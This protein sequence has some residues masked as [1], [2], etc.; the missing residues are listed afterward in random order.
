VWALTVPTTIFTLFFA[1][2]SQQLKWFAYA[3]AVMIAAFVIWHSIS[4][5][6]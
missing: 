5:L 4:S 2:L 3:V 1:S 6:Y